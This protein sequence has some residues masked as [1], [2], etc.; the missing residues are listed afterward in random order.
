M[1]PPRSDRVSRA[2][3]Y[4]RTISN[5]TRTGL[6]PAMARLSRRFRFPSK[7]TSTGLVRVRS[8][9]LTESRLMSFPPATEMFQ[10][11]GFASCGYVFT[12]QYPQRGG[13]PHSDI[14]GSKLHSAAPRVLFAENC[15][16]PSSPLG[17]PR[18]PP[19]ALLTLEPHALGTTTA[20]GA[21]QDLSKRTTFFFQLTSQLPRLQQSTSRYELDPLSPSMPPK[22]RIIL[23]TRQNSSSCQ[24]TAASPVMKS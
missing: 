13:L 17:M 18:H 8:P 5:T 10:F 16:R 21:P 11:A 3:P 20:C 24:T 7:N 2:P 15:Q 6:S 23:G 12:T 1:V 9:L 22:T 14:P 19:N 4:S